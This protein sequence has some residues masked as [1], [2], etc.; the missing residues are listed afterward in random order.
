VEFAIQH[1]IK[2][3][4]EYES[5]GNILHAIQI[6]NSIIDET[7]ESVEASLRLAELYE[8]TDHYQSA[9]KIYEQLTQTI[10]DNDDIAIYFAQFLIRFENWQQA[11]TALKNV[12]PDDEPIVSFLVGYSYFQLKEYE[13]S[14][15]HFLNFIISDEPPEIIHES[16][17]F[18]AKIEFKFSNFDDTI[19]YLK[20]ASVL[21][22]NNWELHLLEAELHYK[23]NSLILAQKAI[24][25]ALK[26]NKKA[27]VLHSWAGKIYLKSDDYKNAENHFLKYLKLVDKPE[28]HNITDLAEALVKQKKFKEAISNYNKAINI[29]PGNSDLIYQ[30]QQIEKLIEENSA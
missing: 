7:P 5:Q 12:S 28:V 27:P 14:R 30:K 10:P 16:Y 8:R 26:L 1:K 4:R 9:F 22:S 13:I 2:R 17:F 15:V 20:K 19:K 21:L 6:Y 11:I 25:T 3:A 29:E 23:M 24:N 18:L